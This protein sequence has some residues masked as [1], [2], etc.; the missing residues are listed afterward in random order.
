M[1]AT[2]RDWGRT[3]SRLAVAG[4]RRRSAYPLATVGGLVTNVMFGFLKAAILLAT[5]RAAG[6]SVGGYDAAQMMAFVWIGQGML[7]LVDLTGRHELGDRILNGDIAVDFARP[8]DVQTSYLAT[9]LGYQSFSLLPRGVPSVLIGA[10][11]TGMAAPPSVAALVLGLVSVLVGM[12]VSFGCV[13]LVQVAGFWLVQVRG[14]QTFY[15]VISG[16][17]AGLFVPLT[18]FPDW[19]RVLAEATPFPSI[20]MAPINV[21][22]GEASGGRAV[23]AVG[24]QLA[25]LALLLAAGAALTSAGRRKLEVQGG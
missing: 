2:I 23:L 20:M 22:T 25:W 4:F 10:A 13:Y 8:L 11:V 5:V 21:L 24:A 9:F 19:L 18:M 16:F 12:A 14:L 17:F 7:G 15:M 3:Y 6:G 1:R